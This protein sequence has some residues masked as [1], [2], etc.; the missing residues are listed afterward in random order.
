MVA[1]GHR[2]GAIVQHPWDAQSGTE[3]APSVTSVLQ[4]TRE[5]EVS[6]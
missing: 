5:Y 2:T 4:D 6:I 3:Q 1:E